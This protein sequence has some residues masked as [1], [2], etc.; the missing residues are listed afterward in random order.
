[1]QKYLWLKWVE[2]R[3]RDRPPESYQAIKPESYCI[4]LS[5]N[6]LTVTLEP[7]VPPVCTY[8]ALM[9]MRGGV[10]V[11]GGSCILARLDSLILP[12]TIY[13]YTYI[14][15][16]AHIHWQ[17]GR[18]DLSSLLPVYGDLSDRK[19]DGRSRDLRGNMLTFESEDRGKKRDLWTAFSLKDVLSYWR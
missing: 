8:A 6:L 3:I 2:I 4:G 18:V 11:A 5:T 15:T 16:D 12:H 19:N 14:S 17:V 9:R 10:A 7:I 1:M 13:T